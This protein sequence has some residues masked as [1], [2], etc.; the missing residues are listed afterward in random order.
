MVVPTRIHTKCPNNIQDTKAP[1]SSA[2]NGLAL[3]IENHLKRTLSL[4]QNP[5]AA[6]KSSSFVGRWGIFGRCGKCGR[7]RYLETESLRLSC[8]PP[9]MLFFI[10]S[11][12][13]EFCCACCLTF[14][15]ML[16]A[17]SSS[18][19]LLLFHRRCARP[20]G[21]DVCTLRIHACLANRLTLPLLVLLALKE[22][23]AALQFGT[24]WEADVDESIAMSR[25][26]LEQ[27]R[28]TLYCGGV[29]ECG[30]DADLKKPNDRCAVGRVMR[31][32]PSQAKVQ[33]L[34]DIVLSAMQD[35]HGERDPEVWCW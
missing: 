13:V 18:S 21:L 29:R 19:A 2:L 7:C 17:L 8:P 15:S 31:P 22:S 9:S 26:P 4:C 6:A 33:A 25:S 24:A 28:R 14:C 11:G 12:S 1:H 20:E 30:R 10:A 27:C 23:A 32:M 35:D 34:L 3:R 16:A 5:V